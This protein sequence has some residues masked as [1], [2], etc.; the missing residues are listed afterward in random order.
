MMLASDLDTSQGEIT[1]N[2][3]NK[4]WA[5]S[6]W[7]GSRIAARAGMGTGSSLEVSAVQTRVEGDEGEGVETA[8]DASIPTSV[9]R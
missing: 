2:V 1:C 7:T 3:S 5:Q 9:D 8:L 6:H 4:S